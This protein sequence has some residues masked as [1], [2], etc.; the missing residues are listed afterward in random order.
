[1]VRVAEWFAEKTHEKIEELKKE[2]A[3]E[4]NAEGTARYGIPGLASLKLLSRLMSKVVGSVDSRKEI[5]Q[6]LQNYATELLDR[7]NDF[8]DHARSVLKA[9]GK[10]DRLLI[11]VDNLDRLDGEVARPLFE[12]G[13]DMLTGVRSDIIYT[14]P[15]ALNLSPYSIGSLFSHV[16]TMPNVKVRLKNGKLHKP[17]IEG[18]L[19]LIRHRLAVELIFESEKVA[20][21]LIE[22]SGGS[23]RDLIRLLD[24]AQ[25]KAQVDEKP[26]VDMTAARAAVKKLSVEFSRFLLPGNVYYPILAEVQRTK[27]EPKSIEGAVSVKSVDDARAF[28]AQ[29]IGNGSVLEYNGEDSWYDVHPAVCETEQFQDACKSPSREKD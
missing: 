11:V 27:H 8:L 18:L 14:A 15:L 2:V 5:R 21:F 28:F 4:A 20:R 16:C 22:K 26:R 10:P 7:V 24:S 23:V 6:R 25:L 17:G 19:G 9:A 13:G 1:M 29:L 12:K 3:V